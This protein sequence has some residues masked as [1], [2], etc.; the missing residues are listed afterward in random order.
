MEHIKPFNENWKD[1]FSNKNNEYKKNYLVIFKKSYEERNN[2]ENILVECLYNLEFLNSSS[3]RYLGAAEAV[4]IMEGYIKLGGA[5][6]YKE[7]EK[8]LF[9]IPYKVKETYSEHIIRL[10]KDYLSEKAVL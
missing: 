2:A 7:K 5:F 6:D 9:F 4:L 10:I 1:V 8:K 3:L